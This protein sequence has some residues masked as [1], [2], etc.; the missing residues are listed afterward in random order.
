MG[1]RS[2]SEYLR[3]VLHQN[4]YFW[5]NFPCLPL[6]LSL[7]SPFISLHNSLLLSN[8]Q[9][10][11]EIN[12]FV[13]KIRVCVW[14]CMESK[15]EKI[16]NSSLL[17][18]CETCKAKVSFIL[19]LHFSLSPCKWGWVNSRTLLHTRLFSPWS[20][21]CLICVTC[22]VFAMTWCLPPLHCVLYGVSDG[23]LSGVTWK[24]TTHVSDVFSVEWW[25]GT[26]TL[27][28]GTLIC[29]HTLK[30][31]WHLSLSRFFATK[32][33]HIII[34]CFFFTIV[35]QFIPKWNMILYLGE[36]YKN[37]S[38]LIPVP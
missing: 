34:P 22:C 4:P 29:V 24:Q 17:I 19:L 31:K 35:F 2:V 5:S 9:S 10:L 36:L 15:T 38:T 28:M 30:L 11:S 32:I 16:L 6:S 21:F 33:Y 3:C 12:C 7:C 18:N 26:S 13:V 37:H 25:T 8:H 23:F 27:F 1:F 20:L 14:K